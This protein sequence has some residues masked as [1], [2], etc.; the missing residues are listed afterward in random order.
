MN[1][2]KASSRIAVAYT[3]YNQA[4]LVRGGKA[5]FE[6]LATYIQ[7]ARYFIH[8]QVYIFDA[9]ETGTHIA[10]LL[11][12]AA[13]RGV[14]VYLMV[15]GYASQNLNNSFIRSLQDDGIHFRFFEPLLKS[16]HF[17]FGRRMHHKIAVFDAQYALVTGV[18]IS[19]RYNDMPDAP[20][21]LDWAIDV[22]GEIVAELVKVCVLFWSKPFNKVDRSLLKYELSGPLPDTECRIRVRRNDWVKNRNQISRSYLEMLLKAKEEVIIMSSYFL[23]GTLIRRQLS[24]AAKRGIRIKLILAAQS[25]IVLAK[26]AER[27]IYRW[28]LQRN[29]ELYEYMPHVLHGKMAVADTRWVTIGSYNV[30]DLSA[31]ASVELNLDVDNAAFATSVQQQLLHIIGQDC[32]RVTHDDYTRKYNG[33]QRFLQYTSYLFVRV[34]FY[35]STFYFRQDKRKAG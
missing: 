35:L 28:L 29:V 31:Y 15:D 12:A 3:R 25:D 16:E 8:L 24:K 17:Y 18:N 10:Q 7:Q 22:Q 23:P 19:N 13:Q 26:Q 6:Q 34:L 2:Q 5:Y 9:D 32:V 14:K 11:K 33:W 30:N 1:R 27:Y 4:K 20:A 21:W